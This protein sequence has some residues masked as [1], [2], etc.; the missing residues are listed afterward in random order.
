M[1][2]LQQLGNDNLLIIQG[3][4]QFSSRPLLS[5]QQ[6]VIGGGQSVRGYRQNVRAGDDGFRLSVEGRIP[7]VRNEA[8]Q[9]ILQVAPFIEAG[10]VW[11]TLS[12]PVL[13]DQRFL[14]SAGLGVIWQPLPQLNLRVDYGFPFTYLPDRGNNL[15]DKAIYFSLSYQP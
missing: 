3:D 14:A 9:P 15:Q 8:G 5:S 1:Q 12:T 11:N 4:L 13:P 7:V 10:G 6:F 2:R